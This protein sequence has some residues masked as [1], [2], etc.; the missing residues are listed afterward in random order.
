MR[1]FFRGGGE[2]SVDLSQKGGATQKRLETTALDSLKQKYT[3][4]SEVMVWAHTSSLLQAHFHFNTLPTITSFSCNCCRSAWDK[5][6]NQLQ[7]TLSGG[8]PPF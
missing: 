8:L 4:G 7:L 5:T 1:K 6:S 2:I 3:N